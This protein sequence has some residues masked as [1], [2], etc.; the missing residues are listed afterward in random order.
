MIQVDR[1]TKWYGPT[2]AVDDISFEIPAGKIVGFLGPNGAGKSTTLRILTGFLPP[3]AGRVTVDG[4]D[5]LTQSRQARARVG[6]LPENTPLYPE[7]R[8]EE[9]L[10]YRGKLLAMGKS[11]RRSQIHKVCDLCGLAAVRRR[12]IGQLSRGNRQRVGLAQALM[13]DPPVLI[14]DEPTA[15]LDPNQVGEV[16]KLI[17]ELR[18][19]HTI[20]LSTHVLP[21]VEK[22]ADEVLIIAHGKIVAKGSPDELRRNVGQGSSVVVEIKANAQS[23]ERAFAAV[24]GL[25]KVETSSQ[26]GWTRAVVAQQ[27]GQDVREALGQTIVTNNWQVREMRHET[28]SLEQFFIEI[29]AQQDRAVAGSAA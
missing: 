5:V 16:R 11:T 1:L 15:S 9:Y 19:Q 18:G 7:M 25:G 27:P 28:A 22:M 17:G 2:L 23:I 20:V 8:V 3:T 14:L 10:N 26:N 13:H 21:E 29:T 4:H 24:N 6:Y 12:L